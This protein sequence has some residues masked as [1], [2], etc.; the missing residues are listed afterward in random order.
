MQQDL[1]IRK[2]RPETDGP[3]R[4][5]LRIAAEKKKM[6]KGRRRRAAN[7]APRRFVPLARRGPGDPWR[8]RRCLPSDGCTPTKLFRREC[9]GV[10]R[11]GRE[12]RILSRASRIRMLFSERR[13]RLREAPEQRTGESWRAW[14]HAGEDFWT[15]DA[16]VSEIRGRRERSKRSSGEDHGNADANFSFAEA[17]QAGE[18]GA[19][20]SAADELK[21]ERAE[22]KRRPKRSTLVATIAP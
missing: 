12:R 7:C 10:F 1:R 14:G 21:I 16:V 5:G 19:G 4:P 17:L 3:E 2:S 8:E 20:R 13:K 6:P 22:N 15:G 11:F 18:N 9:S